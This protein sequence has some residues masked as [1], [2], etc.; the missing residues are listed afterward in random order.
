MTQVLVVDD[1]H[2]TREALRFL[3]E[4]AGYAVT[5]AVDG[6]QGL[7]VIQASDVPLVVLLDFSMP[8][9]NGVEVL[10]E[11]AS[12]AR[13]ANRHAFILMTAMS[14]NQYQAAEEVC[15]KLSA[16]VVVKPFDVY[17]FLDLVASAARRLPSAPLTQT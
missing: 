12:D 17:E 7:A 5:E 6:L 14:A 10:Q 8:K 16:L 13:L 1:D 3:L 4:D 9:L 2:D 15:A 11:V